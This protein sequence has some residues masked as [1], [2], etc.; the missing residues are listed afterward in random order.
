MSKT[1]YLSLMKSGMDN[2]LLRKGIENL[3]A[4]IPK[5]L[6]RMLRKLTRVKMNF[7][8]QL[9]DAGVTAL[10]NRVHHLEA[11]EAQVFCFF[12]QTTEMTVIHNRLAASQII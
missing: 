3:S 8:Q 10:L 2:E 11:L 9:G 6:C 12:A 4:M 7:C 1:K 5:S